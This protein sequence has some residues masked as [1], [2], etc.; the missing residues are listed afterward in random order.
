MIESG[1]L[2]INKIVQKGILLLGNTKAGKTTTSLYLAHQNLQGGRN[3][4]KSIVYK[5]KNVHDKYKVAKIGDIQSVSQTQIPN[6]LEYTLANKQ[7][8]CLID[9][10]GYLDSFGCFR[11]ISNRFFHHQVF[12]YVKNAKFLITFTYNNMGKKADEMKNTFKE[13]LKSF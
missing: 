3:N 10:P 12:S 13:F 1:N 9:C 8:I 4:M 7:K 11:V 5:S 2:E 6:F